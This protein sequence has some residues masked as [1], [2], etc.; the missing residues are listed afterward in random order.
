MKGPAFTGKGINEECDASFRR[1]IGHPIFLM[2]ADEQ[3]IQH[4]Y[5]ILQTG[6]LSIIF[7]N[8]GVAEYTIPFPSC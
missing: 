8:P 5:T 4:A 6:H 7:N 1:W 2:L 3:M